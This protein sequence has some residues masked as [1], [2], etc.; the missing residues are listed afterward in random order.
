MRA[1]FVEKVALVVDDVLHLQLERGEVSWNLLDDR[2]LLWSILVLLV[3]LNTLEEPVHLVLE[4]GHEVDFLVPLR[5]TI[6]EDL[7]IT[8]AQAVLVLNV[9]IHII[10]LVLELLGS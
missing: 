1:H 4:F 2:V 8:V 10:L 5:C 7:E 6:A 3:L 9:T